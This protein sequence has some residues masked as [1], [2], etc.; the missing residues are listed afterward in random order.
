MELNQT[1]PVS[2]LYGFKVDGIKNFGEGKEAQTFTVTYTV[3][4][5]EK[6]CLESF[7]ADCGPLIA[8]K[9]GNCVYYD[10]AT[11]GVMQ[12]LSQPVS[13]L[14]SR[15]NIGV[16]PDL[17]LYPNPYEKGQSLNIKMSELSGEGPATLTIRSITGVVIYKENYTLSATSN[18]I[19]LILPQM[20]SG[21]YIVSL[22]AE[23][24]IITRQLYVL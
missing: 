8:Y 4:S 3:C 9:A 14:S 11:E 21:T 5:E 15:T 10:K 24:H 6:V 19:S 16:L 23:G 13:Q 12:P 18:L 20:P 1:N 22:E 7:T 2:G 17:E